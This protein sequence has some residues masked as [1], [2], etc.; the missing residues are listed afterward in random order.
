MGKPVPEAKD[1]AYYQ[2]NPDYVDGTWKSIEIILPDISEIQVRQPGRIQKIFPNGLT[3][4]PK[5]F[6][7][8]SLQRL[9]RMRFAPIPQ[10]NQP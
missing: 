2:D 10:E 8:S 6:D 4:L 7:K 1:I 3:E 5:L 9:I